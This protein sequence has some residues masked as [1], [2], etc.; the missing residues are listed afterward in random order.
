MSSKFIF[1][2]DGN[3]NKT[4]TLDQLDHFPRH[5]NRLTD[6]RC[7]ECGCGLT[8]RHSGVRA[9]S[10]ATRKN[11]RHATNCHFKTNVQIAKQQIRYRNSQNVYLT[12]KMQQDRSYIFYLDLNNHLNSEQMKHKQSRKTRK[13][14][15]T[16]SYRKDQKT[17]IENR[18]KLTPK[19]DHAGAVNAEN[20]PHRRV[21][22]GKKYLNQFTA[23]D[24][25]QAFKTGGF[26]E[27][28]IIYDDRVVLKL[29]WE[30]HHA[31]I[32]INEAALQTAQINFKLVMSSIQKVS[33]KPIVTML[34]DVIPQTS[35]SGLNYLVRNVNSILFNGE[36]A[37]VYLDKQRM[38]KE[39]V[40]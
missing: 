9:A 36:V 17:K 18:T 34:V 4:Y 11:Q 39:L 8:F 2:I 16:K 6:L 38:A 14:T 5:D 37:A 30:K 24:V 31:N 15:S 32:V 20:F 3:T 28:I 29:E 12:S 33:D 7:P 26:L 22:I 1:A 25:N 19:L 13:R 27:K 21:Q 10:L 40:H 23:N 35:S